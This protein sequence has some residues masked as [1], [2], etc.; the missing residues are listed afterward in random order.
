MFMTDTEDSSSLST[1]LRSGGEMGRRIGDFDWSKTPLGPI[2]Q[3]SEALKNVVGV[4]LFNRFPMLLWWGKDYVQLYND[5]YIPVLG[6][7]H[8]SPGLGNP[9]WACWEEIWDVLAP[10][11]DTPFRGGP[12]TWMDDILLKVNR[13]NRIEETHF[14][15]AYSAVPDATVKGGIGGVL[16]TVNEI[17]DGIIGTRQMETLRKLG[18][19]ISTTLSEE[20]VYTK[21]MS[22]FKD[23][24]LDIPFATVHRLNEDGTTATLVATAGIDADHVDV[25][26]VI[27]LDKTKGKWATLSSA[28]KKNSIVFNDFDK[29][30]SSLPCGGWDLPPKSFIHVPVRA[31]KNKTAV[32]VITM[33]LNPYRQFDDSFSNFVDLIADQVTLGVTNAL[34]FKE[35]QKRSQALAEIDEAKTIFFGNVSH[36]FRTPLTLILGPVSDLLAKDSS[37]MVVADRDSLLLVQRNA[38]RLQK[39]VNSLL[40]FSRIEAGKY[41]ASFRA[42]DI[43]RITCDLASNFTSL[44]RQAG[45][46][47]VVDCPTIPEP[48][49]LDTEMWEKIILNLLSNAFKFTLEGSITLKARLVKD[50]V[51]VIVSDTGVG[52]SKENLSHLFERFHRIENSRSRTHEGSGIGLA[53]VNELVKLHGGTVS[54]DSVEGKGT[55][56][57]VSLPLGYKHLPAEALKQEKEEFSST[58]IKAEAFREEA[59]RWLP[60][61]MFAKQEGRVSQTKTKQRVLLA[62]DNADMQMYIKS[63]LEQFCEV[64]IV[65]NGRAAIELAATLKPDLI[66]SDIMMPEMDGISLVKALRKSE[67]LRTIPVILLSARAGEEARIEGLQSGADDYLIKPFGRNELIARVSS[68]LQLSKLR[69]EVQQAVR[70]S[71]AQLRA[72]VTATSDVIYRM[73]PDWKTMR[74]L[75]GRSFL[76]DTGEPL[77]NWDEK[78]IHPKDRARV[79]K[80]IHEAIERKSIFQLEHQVI[81]TDGTLGWTF[82]RA[83][84]IF[85]ENDEIIEW[86]GAAS[87]ISDRKFYE[88][89]LEARV[90]DRTK[91]LNKANSELQVSNEDLQQFAHVASHD[92]KEP[93]RKIRTFALRLQE[94]FDGTIPDKGK[95]Y[96]GKVL[97]AAQRMST[98]IDGVLAYSSLNADGFALEP[99]D[100][101]TILRNIE[102]DLELVIQQ[103]NVKITS[104]KLPIITGGKVLTHQLFYNLINNSLKFSHPDRPPVIAIKSH[105]EKRDGRDLEIITVSDN[106]IGFRDD[107]SEIIFDTFTRLHSKDQFDGTGLGLALC[108]KIVERF[109]GTIHATG[110]KDVGATFTIELPSLNL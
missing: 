47:F 31:G 93:L 83:I 61:E 18:K 22:A 78:Y 110:K 106:G 72:L 4:M 70:Y 23:S 64:T 99:I 35:E 58:A 109:G 56:F 25:Q 80:A 8:P 63:I 33:A 9:G 17:T 28:I 27:D 5:A 7:K 96:V 29:D 3:W 46:T 89:E 52:I 6:L 92:L 71:E 24:A 94:E 32:A 42:I 60:G 20:E 59:S 54:V 10:L 82:S 74:Q 45:L 11:V 103:K 53:L 44:M 12:A 97:T 101:N 51:E 77:T 67:N 48:V 100:L 39:L 79:W 16:A 55:T 30:W 2:D 68:N 86:F 43:S 76:K 95:E 66:L 57:T 40:D 13:N 91:A 15:I 98:M 81:R 84:P 26:R 36:E 104:S 87:D 107:Q 65:P 41:K 38:W 108:R 14:V 1:T 49:Y 50:H 19:A 105:Q 90:E 37:S 62:E 85:D 88:T 75:D 34:A 21:A 69:R 102:S 73:S